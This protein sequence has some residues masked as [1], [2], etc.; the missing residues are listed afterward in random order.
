MN[1]TDEQARLR[2]HIFVMRLFISN[3]GGPLAD[4]FPTCNIA[5]LKLQHRSRIHIY[6][7]R[8]EDGI[9]PLL[10]C[11][12]YKELNNK[13]HPT[14]SRGREG[15]GCQTCQDVFDRHLGSTSVPHLWNSST[16]LLHFCA[17]HDSVP[18]CA[19][20]SA[21]A[22]SVTGKLGRFSLSLPIRGYVHSTRYIPEPVVA[23]L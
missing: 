16:L 19:E 15:T 3:V 11:G 2:W 9:P 5:K 6:K 1:L 7:S 8:N 20:P 10:A 17:S 22:P 14:S 4:T 18:S 21:I 12:A 13:R 23:A